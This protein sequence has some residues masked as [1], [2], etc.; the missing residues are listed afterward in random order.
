MC[1]L[2]LLL[3]ASSMFV[4]KKHVPCAPPQHAPCEP[5]FVPGE[6]QG[7]LETAQHAWIHYEKAS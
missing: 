2:Y 7:F 6:A 1:I 5:P 4:K 3:A